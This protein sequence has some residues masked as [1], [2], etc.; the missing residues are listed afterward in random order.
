VIALFTDFGIQGP[1][2]G[3]VRA[4]VSKVSGSVSVVDLFPD[5]PAF[6]I[7][8]AACLIPAYSQFLADD[9]VC[10]CVVDPGVGSDRRGLAVHAAGRWYVGP[11]NGLLSGILAVDPGARCHEILWQPEVLS[12]SF[13]GRDWFAPVAAKLAS[14]NDVEMKR[15]EVSETVGVDWLTDLAE[16]VYIDAYG[17]AITGIRTDRLHRASVFSVCE[18][19]LEHAGTFSDVKPGQ[20]FW[21]ENANGLVEIAVNQGSAAKDLGLR[22][23]SL[24]SP[25]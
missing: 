13:H 22:I 7:H 15:I 5:L 18:R 23:G 20:A 12:R 19:T 3:Q 25:E 4:A 9:T 17:N 2:L 8:A 16:V 11:D 6:R 21:Y 14:G 24:V 1:Y 10:L